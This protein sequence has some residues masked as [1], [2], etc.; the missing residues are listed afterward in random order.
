MRFIKTK[1]KSRSV[2]EVHIWY[3]C[4]NYVNF[5]ILYNCWVSNNSSTYLMKVPTIFESGIRNKYAYVI[6]SYENA[7]QTQYVLKMQ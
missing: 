5:Q 7:I 2:L 1:K 4:H 6:I 3:V